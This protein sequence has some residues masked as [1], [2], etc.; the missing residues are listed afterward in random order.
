M[1][2]P[3]LTYP[4]WSSFEDYKHGSDIIPLD[5]LEEDIQ[6]VSSKLS[7]AAGPS[8]TDKLAFQIWML[9]FGLAS[10]SLSK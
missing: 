6:W 4:Q 2:I 5:I 3:N 10:A 7:G 8:L 9:C 1:R